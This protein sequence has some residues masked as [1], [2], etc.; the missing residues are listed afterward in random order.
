MGARSKTAFDM[1][2]VTVSDIACVKFFE[3]YWSKMARRM[4]DRS[5][6]IRMRISWL[7]SF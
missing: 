7:C 2:A 1:I 4:Y 5:K 3:M 6:A